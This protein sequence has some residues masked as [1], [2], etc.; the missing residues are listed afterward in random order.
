MPWR[1]AADDAW[2]GRD[3]GN[4]PRARRWHQAV[5]PWDWDSR[6]AAQGT[7]VI[8][9]YAVDAGV[10]RNKGRSGAAEGPTTLRRACSNLPC[11]AHPIALADG[12]DVVADGDGVLGAQEELA[13]R[14]S[15]AQARGARTLVFGGG[16]DVAFGH[17]LGL[18]TH[19][20]STPRDGVTASV[21]LDA[22]LDNRPV[23]AEGPNSGTSY[24]QMQSWCSAHGRS[25]AA[26]ALGIQRASNTAALLARAQEQGYA[27]QGPASL[28]PDR[29]DASLAAIARHDR[30]HLTVDLDCF[31][32]AYAPG[33]SAP[34]PLGVGPEAAES[35][36]RCIAL[37]RVCGADLAELAPALDPDGRTARLAAALAFEIVDAWS[38]L[39]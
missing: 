37:C 16:H 30:V 23:P 4:D 18:A 33:V 28:A 17:W 27:W 11:P 31:A 8:I 12:G 1:P 7:V 36:R 14:V 19:D 24:S 22:H 26:L 35:I 39:R 29:I 10:R 2:S 32:A 20:G 5:Q 15:S 13:R 6:D 9:G 25:F 38:T 3:D 21:N 34:T